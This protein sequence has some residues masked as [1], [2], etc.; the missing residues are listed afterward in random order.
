[1][2]E[3][4]Y[5]TCLASNIDPVTGQCSQPI[6]VTQPTLWPQ[7]DA[8]SGIAIAVAILICWATAYVYRSLRQVGD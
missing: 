1:M 5:Q 6:W 8:D 7:L 3:Q 2:D 4:L